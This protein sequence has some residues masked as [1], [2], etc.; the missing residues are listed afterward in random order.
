MTRFSWAEVTQASPLRVSLDDGT[1]L[2]MTPST[3]VAGLTVG[4]RVLVLMDPQVGTVIVGQN[5]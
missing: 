1:A 5:Q 3:L 4:A 2:P